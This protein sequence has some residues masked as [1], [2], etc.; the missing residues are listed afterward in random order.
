M[1][2]VRM[3]NRRTDELMFAQFAAMMIYKISGV[4]SIW[5]I[6]KDIYRS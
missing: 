1:S 4:Q 3:P 6:V 5:A 2:H